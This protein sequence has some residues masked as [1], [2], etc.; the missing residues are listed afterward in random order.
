MPRNSEYT[1]ATLTGDWCHPG[2]SDDVHV[3]NSMTIWSG[4]MTVKLDLYIKNMRGRVYWY[5]SHRDLLVIFDQLIISEKYRP[6]LAM[7]LFGT[8]E[9]IIGYFRKRDQKITVNLIR[10]VLVEVSCWC[11]VCEQGICTRRQKNSTRNLVKIF[12]G[13]TKHA[14][15]IKSFILRRQK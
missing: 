3:F 14:H 8:S 2:C 15:P 7:H 13:T 9:T 10:Q 4:R 12:Y 11:F 1:K 6:I 5:H